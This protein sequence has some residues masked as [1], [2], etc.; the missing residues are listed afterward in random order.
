MNIPE[1]SIAVGFLIFVLTAC[2]Q[3]ISQKENSTSKASTWHCVYSEDTSRNCKCPIEFELNDSSK[4]T[5]IKDLFYKSETGHLYEKTSALRQLKGQDTLS[6][7]LYFNGYLSQ[8]IDPLT[9][10]PL[11]G[12]YAKDKNYVYYYRP[13]SGGMQISKIDT[14]DASTFKLLPGHY[15]YA[16]DK[17][18]FYNETQVIEGF[19]PAGTKQK[20][21]S[22]GRV[23]EITCN[24][25][26]YNFELVN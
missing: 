1:A 23:C 15:K 2:Q 14:A 18:Y 24:N 17:N 26:K 25:K 13:V 16:M 20:L 6:S 3:P 10:E 19:L 12:W 5:H 22:K 8:E 11:D 4:L 7:V 9:F 21:D